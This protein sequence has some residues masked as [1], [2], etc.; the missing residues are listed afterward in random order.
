MCVHFFCLDIGTAAD[1]MVVMV[2]LDRQEEREP[3]NTT[4]VREKPKTMTHS[5]GG[6]GKKLIYFSEGIFMFCKPI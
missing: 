2:G 4:R 1:S 5:L 3:R 6:K